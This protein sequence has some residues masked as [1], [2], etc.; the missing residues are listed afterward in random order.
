M[1]KTAQ[2]DK[3][4]MSIWTMQTNQTN[5]AIK[6]SFFHLYSFGTMF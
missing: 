4:K 1:S 6:Q 5:L 3:N 2:S